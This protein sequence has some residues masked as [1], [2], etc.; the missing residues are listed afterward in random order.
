MLDAGKGTLVTISGFTTASGSEESTKAAAKFIKEHLAPL[1]PTAPEVISGEV[2]LL[3]RRAAEE[4]LASPTGLPHRKAP[5]IS[6][7]LPL[8]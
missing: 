2:K 5:G 7:R 8:F 3:E 4:N 6:W 1:V